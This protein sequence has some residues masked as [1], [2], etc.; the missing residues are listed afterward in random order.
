[1]AKYN[2]SNQIEYDRRVR[3]VLEYLVQGWSAGDICRN[4]SVK[5]DVTERQVERYI[6]KAKKEIK[7]SIKDEV[8]TLLAFHKKTRI[9]S[10]RLLLKERGEILREFDGLISEL[11]RI[12][13]TKVEGTK[14]KIIFIN[15]IGQ[16]LKA[17]AVIYSKFGSQILS[18]LTDLAKLEGLYVKKHEHTGKDG[19]AL[20]TKIVISED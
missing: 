4:M 12:K 15:E 14:N 5:W 17:K 6:A 8:N 19:E 3:V 7:K 16:A 11:K 18:T 13:N 2:K 9:D 20:I 1:M 10:Y